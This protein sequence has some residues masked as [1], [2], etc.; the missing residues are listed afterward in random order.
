MTASCRC[1][2]TPRA[3]CCSTARTCSSR[4]ASRCPS[5]RPGQQVRGWAAQLHDPGSEV[6]GI[7][8]RG[9]PGWG[10]NMAFTTTL[11]NTFGGQWFDN[12]L[13]DRRST[14]PGRKAVSFYV[15]LL[16]TTRLRRSSNGFDENLA[17][18]STGK[19]AISDQRHGRGRAACSTPAVAGRGR[20]GFA[21]APVDKH[22]KARTGSWSWAPAIPTSSDAID[23]AKTFIAWAT[24]KDYVE[25]VGERKARWRCPRH[26]HVDYERGTTQDA[27]PFAR[28]RAEVDRDRRPDQH[29]R[30][31]QA[32]QRGPVRPA[33]RSS[34]RSAPGRADD[35]AAL[36]G[37]MQVEQALAGRARQHRAHHAAGRLS[38]DKRSCRGL[39]GGAGSARPVPPRA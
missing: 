9:K 2:S 3:R 34:R 27:A 5:S 35:R 38:R 22:P 17:L 29:D 13:E 37:Q 36:T 7:C 19:C 1:R 6:Y 28:V 23:D 4:P 12:R 24:S 15:D 31:P 18:F 32:V 10:E 20:L 21:Q 11:V 14:A 8:L 26:A 25:L 39:S 16:K 30:Q 33:S